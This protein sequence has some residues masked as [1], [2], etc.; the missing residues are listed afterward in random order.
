MKINKNT[1]IRVDS[2]II[3]EL[4]LQWWDRWGLKIKMRNEYE[5]VFTSFKNFS[6]YF[7]PENSL[8]CMLFLIKYGHLI[9][10]KHKNRIN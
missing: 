4:D 9:K 7:K 3:Q 5:M 6:F 8:K 10:S 1:R 2:K